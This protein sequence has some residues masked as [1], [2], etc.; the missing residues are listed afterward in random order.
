M[1]DAFSVHAPADELVEWMRPTPRTAFVVHGEASASVA[2]R[3]RLIANLGWTAV[4][5]AHGERGRLD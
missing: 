2:L 4:V 3:D 5:A 1:V